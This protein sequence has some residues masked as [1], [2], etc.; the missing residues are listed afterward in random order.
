MVRIALQLQTI[1]IKSL[2]DAIEQ[3]KAEAKKEDE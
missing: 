1:T 3:I 2:S